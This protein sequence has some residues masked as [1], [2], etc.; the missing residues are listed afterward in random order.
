M[1]KVT[2]ET[3]NPLRVI[4][5]YKVTVEEFSPHGKLMVDICHGPGPGPILLS[6][7]QV[8]WALQPGE[9]QYVECHHTNDIIF[10]PDLNEEMGYETSPQ[11]WTVGE[12]DPDE[13]IHIMWVGH[14]QI[15]NNE[16]GTSH[17]SFRQGKPPHS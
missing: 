15:S 4:V 9:T 14:W 17:H 7:D 11:N 13:H 10:S 5:S 3:D 12:I 16:G 6:S 1:P 8:T 2:N